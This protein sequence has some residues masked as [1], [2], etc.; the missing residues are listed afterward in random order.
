MQ[1]ANTILM[2]K[3]SG[4]RFNEETAVN[5]HF[6]IA[7][8]S[9]AVAQIQNKAVNEFNS[10]VSLLQKNGITVKGTDLANLFNLLISFDKLL[11]QLAA[12]NDNLYFLLEQSTISNFFKIDNFSKIWLLLFS[13]IV[14]RYFSSLSKSMLFSYLIFINSTTSLID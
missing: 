3:P 14:S 10:M 11:S 6:Q 7:D 9:Q 4:F 13:K 8:E 2:V 12:G 1:S 5:N